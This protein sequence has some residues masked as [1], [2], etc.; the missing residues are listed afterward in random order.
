MKK[1]KGINESVERMQKIKMGERGKR[2]IFEK[3]R[4]IEG[5]ETER[6]GGEVM[7]RKMTGY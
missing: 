4:E 3:K 6:K 1:S 2:K 5:G 7:K